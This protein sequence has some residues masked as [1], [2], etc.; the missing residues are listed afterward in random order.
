MRRRAFTLIE[1]LTVI[2]VLAVLAALLLPAFVRARENARQTQCL[3]HLRQIALAFSQYTGDWDEAFLIPDA[4]FLP[5][6][7]C[8]EVYEGHEPFNSVRTYGDQLCLTARTGKFGVAPATLTMS[9]SFQV[10]RL[11]S[12]GLPTITATISSSASTGFARLSR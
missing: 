1:L 7:E 11:A 10:T 2:A 9:E 8:G 4:T 5:I 12:D 6:D 3:S